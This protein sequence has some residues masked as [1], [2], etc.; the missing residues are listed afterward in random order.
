LTDGN[1]KSVLATVKTDSKGRYL[2]KDLEKGA[3]RVIATKRLS[4]TRGEQ[5]VELGDGE[6]KTGTDIKLFR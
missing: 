1:R 4:L 5:A 6:Q 3:Y 2:F